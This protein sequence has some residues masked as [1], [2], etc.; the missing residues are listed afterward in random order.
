MTE[1]SKEK[2]GIQAAVDVLQSQQALANLLGVT[3]QAV[4]KWLARGYAPAHRV[5]EIEQGTGVPREELINPRL[6]DLLRRDV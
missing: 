3:Q 5:V 1:T 6:A 4:G 2:P